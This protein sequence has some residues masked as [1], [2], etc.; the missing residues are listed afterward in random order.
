MKILIKNGLILTMNSDLEIIK[1]DILIQD[2]LI[3]KIG[4]QLTDTADETIDG[5]D[6]IILPGFVQS[7]VHL[8]QTLFRNLADDL[9]LLDWLQKKI[10][11]LEGKHTPE[12]LRIS[13]RLGLSEMIKGGT[14]TILDMG[15]VHHH[16]V[17][18]EEMDRSGI[19]GL[20][21]KAMMDNGDI[22]HS[23]LE[24][25]KDSINESLHLYNTWH[26]HDNGRLGYAFAPRFALSCSKKLIRETAELTREL[27]TLFHSH[28]A[29]NKHETNLVRQHF[30]HGN[31]SL[32]DELNAAGDNLC[33]AHCIWVSK[34]E[35]DLMNDKDIKVLHCPT[36]NLK[37]GSGIAPVPE[38]NEMGIT[39]ALGSD[40]APCNNN[41]DMFQEMRLAA[42]IQ[43]PR[44]GPESLTARSVLQMAT[45]NGAKAL[46]LDS[47]TGSIETGKKADMVFIKNHQVHSIPYENMYSKLVYSSQATDVEHVMIDGQWVYKDH[48]LLFEDEDT[49]IREVKD[50]LPKF[51]EN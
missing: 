49:L 8:C 47:E 50:Q 30:G 5:S 21:G 36:A 10:W 23:L 37:L 38:Y 11:P 22:P 48:H 34:D 17:V 26:G 44:L 51:L 4:S 35:M 19:R 12:S 14:T 13:A 25:T 6:F 18:F 31:I 20:S 24:S 2:R 41:M 3:G 29:E 16:N 42:L 43:K 9:S 45:I 39:V 46:G 7:H 27:G 32:F 33:L 40:G 15:T 28:A 1:G